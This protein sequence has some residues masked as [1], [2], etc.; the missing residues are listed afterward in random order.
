MGFN[1]GL[2]RYC[3][4][5]SKENYAQDT[6]NNVRTYVVEICHIVRF[7][8]FL[9]FRLATL[10]CEFCD[11]GLGKGCIRDFGCSACIMEEIELFI[12]QKGV[13]QIY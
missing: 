7:E 5:G 12:I 9:C 4:E 2:V 3:F 1:V 8:G 10:I 13:S 11:L 6:F